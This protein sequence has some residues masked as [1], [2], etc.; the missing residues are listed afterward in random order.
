MARLR[1]HEQSQSR[2]YG[3]VMLA[4]PRHLPHCEQQTLSRSRTIPP[5]GGLPQLQRLLALLHVLHELPA[6]LQLRVRE[7]QLSVVLLSRRRAASSQ[8]SLLQSKGARLPRRIPRPPLKLARDR[9][10]YPAQHTQK[11]E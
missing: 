4:L 10:H 6:L 3:R 9:D 2:D 7:L 11:G 1:C 5:A 8:P